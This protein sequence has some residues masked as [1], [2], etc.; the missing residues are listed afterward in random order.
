MLK[1][2]LFGSIIVFLFMGLAL[3]GFAYVVD[4]TVTPRG[5]EISYWSGPACAQMIMD[6]YPPPYPSILYQQSVIWASIQ[7]HNSGEPGW[8]TDPLGM[9]GALTEL[10]DPA[11]GIWALM[12]YDVKE[13][14]MFQILFWMNQNSFPVTTLVNRGLHW[15][16]VVGYETDIEPLQGSSPQLLEITINDPWP[17]GVGQVSTIVGSVWYD[18]QW[19]FP[20]EKA[21]TWFDK[22]VAIIEPPQIQGIITADQVVRDGDTFISTEDALLYSESAILLKNLGAKHPSYAAL[23]DRDTNTLDPILVREMPTLLTAK[24]ERV[25]YYYIIPYAAKEDN[26]LSAVDT[27]NNSD[28]SSVSIVVNAFTGNFEQVS[29]FGEAIRYLPEDE[30]VKIAADALKLTDADV[31]SIEAEMVYSPCVISSSRANPFWEITV[32]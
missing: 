22:Y 4:L 32:T 28:R 2:L 7:T 9:Q 20:V 16:D 27:K 5:Q 21:G 3:P 15:V 26:V 29:A 18:D 17:V 14:L 30:A 12:S 19:E 23:N 1:R 24:N 8:A 25:P 13:D 31:K 10:N 6:S 11:P